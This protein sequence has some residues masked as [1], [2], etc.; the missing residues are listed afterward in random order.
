MHLLA[1]AKLVGF[2]RGKNLS[3]EYP[4]TL[5]QTCDVALPGSPSLA[6]LPEV[7]D[8]RFS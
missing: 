1:L 3:F 2:A 8:V 5:A 7:C 6:C 4:E